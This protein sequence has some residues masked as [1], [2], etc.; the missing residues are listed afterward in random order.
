MTASTSAR[1]LPGLWWHDPLAE[2]GDGLTID[3][4]QLAAIFVDGV[5][6]SYVSTNAVTVYVIFKGHQGGDGSEFIMSM[7]SAR[8][9]VGTFHKHVALVEPEPVEAAETEPTETP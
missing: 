9:L 7:D 8:S 2:A 1:R 5:N 3:L 4:T 6:D